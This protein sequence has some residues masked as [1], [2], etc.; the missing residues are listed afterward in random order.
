MQYPQVPESLLENWMIYIYNKMT[1][2]NIVVAK[3]GLLNFIFSHKISKL[4][5]V[6]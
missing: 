3:S 6:S 2:S 4:G 5:P 1:S